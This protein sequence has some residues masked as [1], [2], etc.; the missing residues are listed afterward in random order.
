MA[1]KIENNQ[2][3]LTVRDLV[4]ATQNS[5]MLSSFPLPQR[6]ALGRQAQSWLQKNKKSR[7]G[8]FHTEYALKQSYSHKD[9]QFNISGRI[10]GVYLLQNRAEIEEIKSVILKKSLFKTVTAD[11]YPHF[12]HQ[13]LLYTYLLQDELEGFEIVPFLVLINLVDYKDR[14]FPVNYNRPAVEA[15][16]LQRFDSII[17]EINTS[18]KAI[19]TKKAELFKVNFSLAEDRPQQLQMMQAVSQAIDNREH[20]MASAPTGTGKTAASLFPAIR[21]AYAHNKKI[22]FVTS[23]G[24]QQEI[25]RET[26]NLILQQGLDL[27]VSFI[28][29][30][31][32]MCANDI[33]FCHEAHCPY[34]RDYRRR[35]DESGIISRLR[36]KSF[37]SAEM[38]FEEAVKEVLCP[39]EVN[40][41][42]AVHSDV[43]VGDY[44]YVFDPAVQLRKVFFKTDYSDWILIID[45]AHNLYERGMGYLSP[46]ISRRL[47]KILN[48]SLRSKK[49][50]VYKAL[51]TALKKIDDEFHR[52]QQEGEA[53]FSGHQYFETQLNIIAWQD[54][55][56]LFESAYIS[57]LVHKVKKSLLLIDDPFESFYFTFR[58]FVQVLKNRNTSF[59]TYYDAADAGIL[60]IQCCD[61]AFFLGEKIEQFHSVIAMSATLDP[62]PYYQDVLG[63]NKSRTTLLELDS[64]FPKE[65]RQV[66]I[67]PGVSTRYKDRIKNYPR[68]AEIIKE[69][70]ALKNGNYLVFFPSYDFLQNVNLFLGNIES[71]KIIQ[72]PGMKDADRDEIL[73]RM[74]NTEN[75]NL[76]LA[77]MGGI[78][79][80]GVD[81]HGEMA[82]GVIVVSPALPRFGYQRDLLFHYYENKSGMGREYAYMYPGMNKVIQSVGRLIRSF[83]DKGIVILIGERFA[84][85]DFN[86]LLP[87][88]WF[89]RKNDIVIT[90]NYK[91]VIS[92]FWQK[93]NE[94][95]T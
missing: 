67:I 13:L 15:L 93:V 29:A 66:I 48:E 25:V 46:Q 72:K 84:E 51:K 75:K 26:L 16:L 55:L 57:Y 87:A 58:R 59:V 3:Y 6:G 9:F 8:L 36:E 33:Y 74:K 30:S 41:D 78:F 18:A 10:D 69:T 17:E 32:K 11:L 5:Q 43:L 38:V 4:P 24:T 42:L 7:H 45:E 1:I 94:K 71:D 60:N 83:T 80:E 65:N 22:M 34:A 61:P 56:A 12:I 44:N 64:P 2:I 81:F 91:P 54:L 68:I 90:D 52:L 53:S 62:L 77:V 39:Y 21:Y 23:K 95:L 89:S 27:K 76:L 85:D 47:L 49:H 63:F 35:L 70:I 86:S 82:I 28:K 92:E 88:Y 19:E 31:Q 20:L 40:L 37:L 50:S 14:I 79:S 73:N